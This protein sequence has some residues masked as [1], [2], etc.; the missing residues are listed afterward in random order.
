MRKSL[1]N[2]RSNVEKTLRISKITSWQRQWQPGFEGM[3]NVHFLQPR[4]SQ[5]VISTTQEQGHKSQNLHR[6]HAFLTTIS[7]TQTLPNPFT[8]IDSSSSQTRLFSTC[9]MA[10][11]CHPSPSSPE[12]P[13][14]A[15]A[16]SSPSPNHLWSLTSSSA[17]EVPGCN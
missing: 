9:S 4:E 17:A 16:L 2:F 12:H 3:R 14:F 7:P 10:A 5:H 15:V 13:V 8:K 6:S 11:E 1:K